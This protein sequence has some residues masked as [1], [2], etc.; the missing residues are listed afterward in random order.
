MAY[1]DQFD[2][3][4][5]AHEHF[6]P[7][8]SLDEKH[9]RVPFAT[10]FA[11]AIGQLAVILA[12][13]WLIAPYVFAA[14]LS[15]PW[16]VVLWTIGLGIPVSLFEY[17][18]HRY[19]LHSAVLPFMSSMSRAHITHHGLTNVK[20][21]VK[22][23]EPEKPATVN[24]QFP[25]EHEH[26]EESMMFPLYSGLIFVAVFMLIMG[27]PLKLIFFSQPIL[28]STI[29]TVMLYY[30]LYEVWHALLHLPYDK[31][32]GPLMKYKIVRRVYG[33]H[34][35]HHWRPV[36]N[37]A[38]V[39]FWGV[40][41]WDHVF[42]THRRPERMPLHNAQVTYLDAKLRRPRWPVS[43]FDSWQGS[44]ARFSRKAERFLARVFLGRKYDS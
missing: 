41:L 21:P 31:Y 27:I 35:M 44:W 43:M 14:E 16:L 8:D 37:L 26:Q 38:I 12:V 33:F 19:L 6:A 22:A 18:Y 1:P 10:F 40:A 24:S 15:R 36:S 5:S 30:S 13:Y 34:L 32:W 17:F 42:G 3:Q 23:H 39:G 28:I 20:A 2:P 29:F 9:A 7:S 25:V 11:A 4:D